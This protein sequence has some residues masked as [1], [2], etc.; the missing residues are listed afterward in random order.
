MP[1]RRTPRS[2]SISAPERL[3]ARLAPSGGFATIHIQVPGGVMRG[4]APPKAQGYKP[5]GTTMDKAG[6]TLNTIYNEYQAYLGNGGHGPFVSSQSGRVSL[7]GTSGTLVGID[8]RA[9][10]DIAA[11]AAQLKSQG[12]TITATST[13]FGIVEGTLPIGSLPTVAAN[14]SVIG[15]DPIFKPT[16]NH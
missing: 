7:S 15:V 13:Q 12:M 5:T 6:Q 10:G 8:V 3:D 16:R 4:F 9:K 1:A 2:L 14:A 11:L